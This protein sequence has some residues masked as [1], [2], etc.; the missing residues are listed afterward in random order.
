MRVAGED[1]F[2]EAGGAQNFHHSRA[3][4]HAR[5]VRLVNLKRLGDYGSHAHSRIERRERI[6]KHHLHFAAQGAQFGAARGEKIAAF[7]QQL[8]RVRL[9][10][11]QK[12]SRE[13]CLSAAGL[14]N[15]RERFAR[16]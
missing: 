15:N 7:D 1:F 4:F 11:T 3:A 9:D 5:K 6:L 13:R 14:T 12:H 10:Q 2:F 8:A 16:G